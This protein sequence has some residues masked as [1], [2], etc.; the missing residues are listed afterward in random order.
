MECS[1]LAGLLPEQEVCLPGAAGKALGAGWLPPG[2]SYGSKLD[3]LP[4]PTAFSQ[5]DGPD[6]KM[7][8]FGNEVLFSA[9][10]LA[11]A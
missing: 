8:W 7:S 6:A 4:E 2:V 10:V 5:K 1:H 3:S 9:G 11:C